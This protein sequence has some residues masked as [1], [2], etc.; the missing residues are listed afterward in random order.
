[1]PFKLEDPKPGR[2]PYHRIRGTYL[3]IYLD[4]STKTADRATANQFSSSKKEK[5]LA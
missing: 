4:R 5:W 3:G 2:S 1:M